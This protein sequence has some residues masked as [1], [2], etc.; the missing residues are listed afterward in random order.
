[1]TSEIITKKK[2]I[3]E[4]INESL[5]PVMETGWWTVS[6]KPEWKVSSSVVQD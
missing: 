4:A 2:T 3:F 6:S 1:V 5:I